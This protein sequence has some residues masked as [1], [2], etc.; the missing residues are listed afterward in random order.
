M[1]KK[2]EK[3]I[4]VSTGYEMK[5]IENFKELCFELT[6]E[7]KLAKWGDGGW[8]KEPEIVFFEFAGYNCFISRSICG[9]LC[10]YVKVPE[11]HPWHKKYYDDIDAEVH[12]GLTFSGSTP[13][14]YLVGFDC[15][16]VYDLIPE[17]Y[18]PKYT[19]SQ[20]ALLNE[21]NSTLC[22]PSYKNIDFVVNECKRLA[23]QA[24][25]AYEKASSS[26]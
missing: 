9:S 21:M 19:H 18:S 12:G 15:A 2:L 14:G 5:N 10:G 1:M 13:N 7:E 4:V 6:Q 16:H 26:V 11:D 24:K 23:Y 22:N 20:R 3:S 8:V 17:V 25:E